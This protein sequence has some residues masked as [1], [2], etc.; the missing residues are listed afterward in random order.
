MNR[1]LWV[2]FALCVAVMGG[3]EAKLYVKLGHSDTVT[4]VAF[5]PDGRCTSLSYAVF[6]SGAARAL[7]F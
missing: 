1:V 3:A 6:L 4:S 2:F 7:A 5:S